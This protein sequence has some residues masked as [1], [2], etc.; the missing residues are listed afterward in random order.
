MIK[1]GI[2]AHVIGRV[3]DAHVSDVLC[4]SVCSNKAQL[5]VQCP[6]LSKTSFL[7]YASLCIRWYPLFNV[8][9]APTGPRAILPNNFLWPHSQHYAGKGRRR[10][11]FSMQWRVGCSLF[12]LGVWR[13]EREEV[14][15]TVQGCYGWR[16]P[17][18][19]ARGQRPVSFPI[20]RSLGCRAT[21]SC[22]GV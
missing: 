12:M 19:M 5:K 14:G 7:V 6:P 16:T 2:S 8:W 20:L 22:P 10:A 4:G 3:E 17:F 1:A 15:E 11:F 21:K 9:H 18:L 13:G